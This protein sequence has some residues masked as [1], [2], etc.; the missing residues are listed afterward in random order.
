MASYH[1]SLRKDKKPNGGK[2]AGSEHVE[3]INRDG[4]YANQDR[5]SDN[6][7]K[8]VSG[9]NLFNGQITVLY[10]SPYGEITNTPNGI[11]ISGHASPTTISIA[12]MVAREAYGENL[13]LSGTHKFKTEAVRTAANDELDVKFSDSAL[14]TEL[15]R[16]KEQIENDRRT[17]KERGG[18]IIHSAK[19]SEQSF[20]GSG[21]DGLA[22]SQPVAFDRPSVRY[23]PQCCVDNN[24]PGSTAMLLSSDAR[25]VVENI[26]AE[27][28]AAVRWD[29]NRGRRRLAKETARKIVRNIEANY[30][31][32]FAESHVEY[33]NREKA[34]AQ[35][36]GCIHTEH[37]LPKWA[38]DDPKKFFKA[39]D[40]YENKKN[41]RY[42]EF[43]LSL[44]NELTL[45]QNLEIVHGFIEK[46]LPD[47][48]YTFAIHD[49]IGT[50][51]DGSHN[52]H[53]HLMVCPRLID[54]VEKEKERPASAYFIDPRKKIRKEADKWKMGAH[55]DR[56]LNS[57]YFLADARRDFAEITNAVLKKYGRP[58]R[59][60]HRSIKAMREEALLSGD[61]YMARILDRVP[62]RPI[63][64]FNA[65]IEDNVDVKNQKRFRSYKREKQNKLFQA[66]I[67]KEKIQDYEFQ[68]L[69][70]DVGEQVSELQEMPEY[71][72]IEELDDDDI[73]KELKADF[74]DAF[75]EAKNIADAVMSAEDIYSKAQTDF[76]PDDE[77][78]F[79]QAYHD[80]IKELHDWETFTASIDI[81]NDP[82]EYVALLPDLNKKMDSIENTL[83]EMLP[84]IR[85]LE[86]MLSQ[87]ETQE[88]IQ[89][90]A[91]RLIMEEKQLRTDYQ[92]AIEHLQGTAETLRQALTS[93]KSIEEV[94]DTQCQ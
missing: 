28:S 11:K 79:W 71:L 62:E 42:L 4:K 76:L 81:D 44:P 83:K 36:G 68:Q 73:C 29:R 92:N 82:Q 26:R 58:D 30:D 19:L 60:D 90:Y 67:T 52:L 20:D 38:K 46:Q 78:E 22:F 53:V 87:P 50:M 6:Y 51:S 69:V 75:Q 12:M 18:K 86:E 9:K 16:R 5:E 39:A 1:F 64:P 3:Y 37:R 41:L 17:F 72:K 21:T 77:K 47:H 61:T 84:H 91:H 55:I 25:T 48:Y 14:Q 66:F 45:E 88:R 63:G 65:L 57:R 94:K 32:V 40:R 27:S 13:V 70:K 2:V 80:Q 59:V 24:Q 8:P 31:K 93:D 49:K 10:K 56:R 74:E 34:F 89:N 15:R 33:I 7:I 35:R 85:E 43:Q 23:L 54:D